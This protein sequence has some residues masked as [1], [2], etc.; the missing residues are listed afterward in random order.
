MLSRR[1]SFG[2]SAD[3]IVVQMSRSSPVEGGMLSLFSFSFSVFGS[4]SFGYFAAL[5]LSLR[6]AVWNKFSGAKVGFQGLVL[7]LCFSVA[8]CLVFF[9]GVALRS[10]N[11][12]QRILFTSILSVLGSV[13]LP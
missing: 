13:S 8:F 9:Y 10:R 12:F 3:R 1:C 2:C 5:S 4:A 7:V 11:C 6:V